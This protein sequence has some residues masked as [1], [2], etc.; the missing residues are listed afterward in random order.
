MNRKKACIAI[1]LA[2]APEKPNKRKESLWMKEW[3]KKKGKFS[4]D[5]LLN[6]LL[7]SPEDYKNFLRMD[8]DAFVNLLTMVTPLIE[9]INTQLRD[10]IPAS[11]R[12]SSTLRFL[13][14]GESFEDLNFGTC[15]SPQSLGY[16][17]MH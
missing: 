4:H 1:L 5:L 3:Y 10:A 16:M 2:V 12:L 11:E 9:K 15:I 14:T 7:S 13:A 6:E 17:V 8:H